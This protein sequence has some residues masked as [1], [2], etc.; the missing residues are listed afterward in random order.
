MLHTATFLYPT[1]EKFDMDY[2]L[3]KHL[4]LCRD[5]W[6]KHGLLEWQVIQLDGR[7]GYAVQTVTHWSA[8]TSFG[9]AMAKDGEEIM[10]DVANF[11]DAKPVPLVGE[12]RGKATIK[13]VGTDGL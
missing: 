3:L 1:S 8:V 6:A 10:A 9:T 2:Y 4:P 11:T 13:E 7:A 5:K 12:V